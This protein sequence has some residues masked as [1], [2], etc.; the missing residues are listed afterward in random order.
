MLVRFP[1]THA[2]RN[3]RSNEDWSSFRRLRGAH[4]QTILVP[5]FV[6]LRK[7]LLS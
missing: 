6:P 7:E 2:A 4:A 1:H 3:G 5:A